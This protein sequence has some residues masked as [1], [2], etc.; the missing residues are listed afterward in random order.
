[1]NSKTDITNE[2]LSISDVVGQVP[3]TNVFQV[4]EGY[5]ESIPE[6]IKEKIFSERFAG[7]QAPLT[8]PE[9]YFDQLPSIILAKINATS[10]EEVKEEIEQLSPTLASIPKTNLFT[11]PTGYFEQTIAALPQLTQ[12]TAAKVIAISPRKKWLR[13]A[14]AAVVIGVLGFFIFTG[15]PTG[16]QQDNQNL[17][18]SSL[19]KD[20]NKIIKENNFDATLENIN[21]DEI[22]A[23]LLANGVDPKTVLIALV[24]DDE[25]NLPSAE[26]YFYNE[27]TLDDFLKAQKLEN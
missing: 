10:F 15:T 2:L 5:F 12:T 20:A 18:Q 23:Y 19:L 13:V 3:K 24:A 26:D 6:N 4:P 27:N 8:V 14:V 7:S 1:M 21:A 9:G 17:S 11:V 16:Q 22:E 25:N